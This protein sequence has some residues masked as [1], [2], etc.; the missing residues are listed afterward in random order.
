MYYDPPNRFKIIAGVV[1]GLAVV[2]IAAILIWPS[3]DPK[4]DPKAMAPVVSAA[5]PQPAPVT[6]PVAPTPVVAV[7]AAAIAATP[8]DA[9]AVTTEVA[10]KPTPVKPAAAKPRDAKPRDVKPRDAKPRDPKPRTPKPRRP[11]PRDP[12]PAD[13]KPP[14][15][16]ATVSIEDKK[17]AEFHAQLGR[18]SLKDGDIVNAAKAFKKA[19]KLNPGNAIAITGMGEIAL[20][21]GRYGSAVNHLKKAAKRRSRSARTHTL[22]GEAYLGANKNKLA[23]AS[24]KRGAQGQPGLRP[25][26]RG[27]PRGDRGA[28]ERSDRRSARDP[29]PA[30]ECA[31]RAPPNNRKGSSHLD[32]KRP[33][34]RC[35][36]GAATVTV[37]AVL[38]RPESSCCVA[39]ASCGC[40]ARSCRPDL[41]PTAGR[42]PWLAA[43]RRV[44]GWS[45]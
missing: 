33:A 28:V 21:Q 32:A 8:P 34:A 42:R 7:D 4:S 19:K 25:S 2:A 36:P 3:D 44:H 37:R 9:G 38:R 26:P 43:S 1:G 17:Q 15:P 30:R 45:G 18:R 31:R 12:K 39:S 27:L 23:A 24:F 11:K 20:S 6:K 40:C 35:R 22:L 16:T 14:A 5:D 29:R 13:V 41:V 10:P